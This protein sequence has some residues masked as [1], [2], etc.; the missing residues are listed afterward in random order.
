MKTYIIARLKEPSTYR[1]LSLVA[2]ALGIYISPELVAAITSAGVAVAGLIG[3][4]FPS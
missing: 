4:L 2:T 1:G 3:I